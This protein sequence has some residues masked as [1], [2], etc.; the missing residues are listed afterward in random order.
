MD[1]LVDLLVCLRLLFL[2]KL[3]LVLLLASMI[4]VLLRDRHFDLLH[5]CTEVLFEHKVDFAFEKLLLHLSH[6]L[7]LDQVFTA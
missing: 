2:F 4:V 1:H 6:L 7:F 3:E 5:F